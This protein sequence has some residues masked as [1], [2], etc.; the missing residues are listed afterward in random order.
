MTVVSERLGRLREVMEIR[1][2]EALVSA[3]PINILYATGVRN[4]SVFSMMGPSRFV[5]VTADDLVL[6]EF[7]GSEHLALGS[8]ATEVLAAPSITPVF[9]PGYRTGVRRLVDEILE[10]VD[11]TVRSIAVERLDMDVAESL[12]ARG[13]EPTN[14]T[15]VFVASRLIKTPGEI[16]LMWSSMAAT[17]DAVEALR[18]TLRPGLTEVEVW[19]EF[20][21]AL[22]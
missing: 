8:V 6:W 16:A 14:A 13:V 3:D 4:M 22:M 20:H 19:A 10:R 11:A 15:E 18:R 5:L 21:R 2:V 1:G 9:D 7:P 17:I 12:R